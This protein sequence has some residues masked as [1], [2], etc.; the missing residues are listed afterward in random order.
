MQSS[1][2]IPK[3]TLAVALMHLIKF[4]V[5]VLEYFVALW[6]VRINYSILNILPVWHV[7][8]SYDLRCFCAEKEKLFILVM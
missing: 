4:Y 1:G 7:H 5:I 2:R 6:S 3:T 8:V